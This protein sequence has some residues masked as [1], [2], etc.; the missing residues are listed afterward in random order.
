MGLHQCIQLQSPTHALRAMR[1]PKLPQSPSKLPH[2]PSAAS[3]GLCWEGF[4]EHIVTIPLLPSH[5]GIAL[6][7]PV[8]PQQV[9]G[10][11][12][13]CP[14]RFWRSLLHL[15]SLGLGLRFLPFSRSD[16]VVQGGKRDLGRSLAVS[17]AESRVYP[18]VR[19]DVSGL[20]LSGF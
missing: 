5:I 4:R 1:L 7:S 14:G 3:R 8:S 13:S 11:S 20:L 10:N 19:A 9:K 17:A 15:S 18:E 12:P 6:L 16:V 2:G